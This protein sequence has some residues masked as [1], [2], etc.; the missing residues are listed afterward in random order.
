MS[1]VETLVEVG[2]LFGSVEPGDETGQEDHSG[3]HTEVVAQLV[4]DQLCF[5]D[6]RG[7]QVDDDLVRFLEGFAQQ[8]DLFLGDDAGETVGHLGRERVGL[9]ECSVDYGWILVV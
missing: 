1:G 7:V 6:R 5:L 9:F 2:V 3:V 8:F 4:H